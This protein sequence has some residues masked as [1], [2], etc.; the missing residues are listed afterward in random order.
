[1]ISGRNFT[2]RG[3]RRSEHEGHPGSITDHRPF[4]ISIGL[5][6]ALLKPSST[7][8]RRQP[9]SG[10]LALS[11]WKRPP[12]PEQHLPQDDPGSSASLALTDARERGQV[13]DRGN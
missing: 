12:V 10:C 3:G 9:T 8:T 2:D 1:M 7:S 4:E 6:L 5:T 13:I 11:P